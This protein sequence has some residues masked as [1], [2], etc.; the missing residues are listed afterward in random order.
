MWRAWELARP[1]ARTPA[2]VVSTDRPSLS[3]LKTRRFS[4][5][6]FP[7]EKP[8]V[9]ALTDRALEVDETSFRHQRPDALSGFRL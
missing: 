3:S 4:R 1:L 9:V 2:S 6:K 5:Y 7:E 8:L